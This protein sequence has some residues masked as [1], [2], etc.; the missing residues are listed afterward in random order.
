M[1]TAGNTAVTCPSPG[2]YTG[3]S[4]DCDR[5]TPATQLTP[6]RRYALADATSKHYYFIIIT[7]CALER[8]ERCLSRVSNRLKAGSKTRAIT[9][10]FSSSMCNRRRWTIAGR[11]VRLSI[12]LLDHL[13]TSLNFIPR[14]AKK[15]FKSSAVHLGHQGST[16]KL[17]LA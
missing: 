17:S 16:K 8:V 9:K 15:L 13:P 7:P 1:S 5:S 3:S 11:F 10:I 2:V 12:R 6:S 14:Q 4:F